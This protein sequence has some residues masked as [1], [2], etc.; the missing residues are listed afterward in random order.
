MRTRKKICFLYSLIPIVI[1]IVVG[2]GVYTRAFGMF[3]PKEPYVK[4]KS[5]SI[6]LDSV[7]DEGK[8]WIGEMGTGAKPATLD[9]PTCEGKKGTKDNP[10]VIL[11]IVADKAQQQMGYL[12]MDEN[13]TKPLDVL[14]YGI[15]TAA[16]QKRSYVPG[17][18]SIMGQ[19][20]LKEIGQWFCNWD[21]SVYKIGKKAEK[22]SIPYTEIAK[23]YQVEITSKDLEKAGVSTEAFDEQLQKGKTQKFSREVYDVP[24]LI[25]KYPDFFEKDSY[26]NTIRKPAKEDINNWSVKKKTEVVKE[27]DLLEGV[28]ERYTNRTAQIGQYGFWNN[29]T[30]IGWTSPSELY[31]YDNNQNGKEASA[32][33]GMMLKLSDN[34]NLT[35][36][37]VKSPQE[38]K[39]VYTFSYYGLKN[40]NVLK[41]QLFHFTT[42]EAYDDF[43]M[44][45][46]CMTPSELN[47]IGKKDT[48]E[49]V[50]MIERA[51]MFYLG[52]YDSETNN[53][54]NV[55]KLYYKY[56][57]NQKD[58]QY[59]SSKVAEF[60]DE[61]LDWNLCFKLIYRLCNNKNLP[62]VTTNR[63]G[64]LEKYGTADV[65]MY[66]S[67][68][69]PNVTRKATLNNLAKLYIIASQFDLTAKKEEDESYIRTFYDDIL[70]TGKLE[71][72]ALNETAKT[73][74]KT[75][76]DN[77][78]YY[79][80]PKTIET[81]DLTEKQK[82]YYLWNPLTFYPEADEMDALWSTD[83]Q[84]NINVDKFVSYGYNRSY[85]DVN[86]ASNIFTS[87]K[88]GM[89]A[90]GSDGEH[91]NVAIPQ[92]ANNENYSTLLG[93]TENADVLN[94]AMDTA[95]QIMNNRPE[96]VNN[97]VV[98]AL[99]QAKKYVK[100][101]DDSV[102][103]DYSSDRSYTSETSYLKV[104]IHDNNNTEDGLV[105]KISL[106]NESG[107]TAPGSNLILY[108][109]KDMTT[110]CEKTTYSGKTGY[111][112][113]TSAPLTAYIPY[114]IKDWAKGYNIIE[115]E[116]VG[117][118][119]SERK[120]KTIM[121]SP[122]I[123]QITIGERTLFSLE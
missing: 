79:V 25:K 91:G 89:K 115:F 101:A 70:M 92:N 22:E 11:E 60:M 43:H 27:E 31:N 3:S 23:L 44:Q 77:T 54:A 81:D 78:G 61:D 9:V 57:E 26:K 123:S 83:S 72:I 73:D 4:G 41:R 63:L 28:L 15:D 80:R 117:R 51:D 7:T 62:L 49:K 52:S 85:F 42:Q 87:S 99:K 59:D 10:F 56:V 84:C 116:T 100:L 17:S 111:Q 74:A 30:N 40:N 38:T 48:K 66:Q 95:F 32:L 58:Y 97:L 68:K 47:A 112:V 121:G 90:K 55:Y 13:E 5:D 103:I 109:T 29:E 102:L 19:D 53:I 96:T 104:Q 75:P 88:M 36:K 18:S 21:Y 118:T 37:Y 64:N 35:S 122:V 6:A 93:N 106:K 114:S 71:Q 105:T 67:K 82:C 113:K 39:E 108:T 20:N 76:A 46:I 86:D 12:A 16:E 33:T 2:I 34:S 1:A 110:A 94:V 120:K 98:K 45:V 14:Q 107:E 69:T 24:A 50:D 8:N 65:K 119:Y